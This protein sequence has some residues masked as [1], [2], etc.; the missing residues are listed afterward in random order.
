[1]APVW[2][3]LLNIPRPYL[4]A[5]ILFFAGVGAYAVNADVFDLLV[6][7]VIGVLGFVMRRYGLPVLP[8]IIGVILGPAA[9]QQMRRAL[10]LSDG[11]LTGLVNTPFSLVVY[12][13]V[14]VLLA[15][16]LVR[17]LLREPTSPTGAAPEPERPKVDA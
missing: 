7:F 12:G 5:G 8:A 16:P 2:A 11:S 4:Y 3:K 15:W 6:M 9:E 13:I 17:R 1:L 10:Q 14:V